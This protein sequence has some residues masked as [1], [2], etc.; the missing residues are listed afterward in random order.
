MFGS[1]LQVVCNIGA[2][3][4]GVSRLHEMLRE[5]D[6]ANTQIQW[7]NTKMRQKRYLGMHVRLAGWHTMYS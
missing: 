5:Q 4:L 6:W 2:F 3:Y 1:A 7:Q